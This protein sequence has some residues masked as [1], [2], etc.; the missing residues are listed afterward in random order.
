MTLTAIS[1]LA[2]CGYRFERNGKTVKLN[3]QVCDKLPGTIMDTYT[4]T[5]P[6]GSTGLGVQVGDRWYLLS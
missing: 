5:K 2:V 1:R 4:V 6:N 3:M